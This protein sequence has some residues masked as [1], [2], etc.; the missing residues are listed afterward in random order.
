MRNLLS[1]AACAVI[2]ACANVSPSPGSMP[3]ASADLLKAS[4][5]CAA[6]KLK[7]ATALPASA[8]PDDILRK[9]QSGWVSIRYDVIAGK[10]Q[11]LKV[12]SSSPPGLYDAFVLRHASTYAEPT[13]STVRGCVMTVNIKF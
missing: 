6:A 2:A 7:S 4:A 11:N 8:I 5:E 12:V 13:G 10:A 3:N 1:L 9:A